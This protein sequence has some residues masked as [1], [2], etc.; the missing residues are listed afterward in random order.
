M[1]IVL[2]GPPGAGKGTQAH[3]VAQRLSL[4]R[5]VTGDIFRDAVARGDTLGR[6]AK[7]YLDSGALVPDEI[8]TA[9]IVDRLQQ[10]DCRCG[11]VLDGFPR[12]LAQAQWFDRE[13]TGQ[14][15]AVTRVVNIVVS[16][17]EV[18]RRLVGRLTCRQC[19]RTYHGV[20][21]PPKTPGIC[22]RCGGDLIQRADDRDET[23]R[24]R[25][26]VY[27]AQTKP[28]VGYYR[29]K[30]L[31]V[32]VDGEDH[33]EAVFGRIIESLPRAPLPAGEKL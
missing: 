16:D 11:A 26:Q 15:R 32:D 2:L 12:T 27:R 23:V 13:L 24:R 18:L 25:L 9:L 17:R 3:L 22:D 30:G 14:H 6:Q 21:M 20:S 31:L 19:Q 4:P 8:T 29:N 1:L 5:I 10:S 33:A 7:P 28:V